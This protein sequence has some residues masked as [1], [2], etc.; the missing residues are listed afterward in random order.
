MKKTIFLIAISICNLAEA[1]QFV[2]N[3]LVEYE[4]RVDNHKV[5]GDDIW[6]QSIKDRVPNFS[7][8]WYDLAFNNN[9]GVYKFNRLDEK[10]KAPSFLGNSQQDNIWFSDYSSGTFTD[11]KNIFGDTYLLQDTLMNIKWK[12]VPNE[13]RE[14]AGFN[15]RK[16]QAIIFDSVYVFAFYTDEITVPGGP[17]GIHGLPGMILGITIPR[18]YTSWIADKVE[19]NGVNTAA[20]VVAPVEG[21]KK[22]ASE[23]L[24]TVKKATSDWGSYAQQIIWQLFL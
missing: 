11:E 4:V 5:L 20:A 8:S 14:I 16:A 12:L 7:V 17:M 1:Q 23:L 15:C 10:T 22:K 19:V 24:Q 18:M 2:N 21:K 6:A 3:G 9:K 13:T